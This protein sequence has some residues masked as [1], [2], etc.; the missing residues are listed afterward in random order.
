M[1]QKLFASEVV[2]RRTNS[3]TTQAEMYICFNVKS[4][5]VMLYC[6]GP[7]TRRISCH[8]VNQDS[9]GIKSFTQSKTRCD[10]LLYIKNDVQLLLKH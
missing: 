6:K 4:K 8:G 7:V 9:E 1:L 5:A 2:F 3:A 10:L